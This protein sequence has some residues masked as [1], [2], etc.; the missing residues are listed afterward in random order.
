MMSEHITP[1]EKAKELYYKFHNESEHFESTIKS[2]T[3]EL[4][5]MCVEEIISSWEEDG[6]KRLDQPIIFWWKEVIEE[7]KKI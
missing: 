1:K 6:H 5:I 7:I 2:S 3:I 4:S